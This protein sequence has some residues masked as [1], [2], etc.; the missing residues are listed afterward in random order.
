M[1]EVYADPVRKQKCR[2]G[3]RTQI[4][5][6][7]TPAGQFDSRT[8]AAKHYGITPAAMGNRIKDIY[9]YLEFYYTDIGPIKPKEKPKAMRIAQKYIRKVKTPLGIFENLRDAATAHDVHPDTIKYRMRSEPTKYKWLD[10]KPGPRK[11]KTPDGI[12]NSVTETADFYK[13]TAKTIRH[14]ITLDK[15]DEFKLL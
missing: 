13:V 7:T 12:F 6:V 2:D 11:V 15:K 3:G 8:A 14:W 5:A 1:A 4:R 10:D 9:H